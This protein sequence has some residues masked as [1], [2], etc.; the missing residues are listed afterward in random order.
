MLGPRAVSKYYD[1]GKLPGD[2]PSHEWD[3]FHDLVATDEVARC[4]SLG[5]I[6]ALG[7]GNAIGCNPIIEF[8]TEEQKHAWL[9][10]VLR[11]DTTFCQGITEPTSKSK[12]YS[13]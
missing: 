4:G 5:L 13:I 1:I 6:W 3:S 2:V 12:F 8:G 9:P 11:G 10:P 7:C